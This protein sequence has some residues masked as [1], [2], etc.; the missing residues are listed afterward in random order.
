MGV[1]KKHFGSNMSQIE[2]LPNEVLLNIFKL[3][4][5]KDLYSCASVS[6][7]FRQIAYEEQLWS[8]LNLSDKT[9]PIAFVEQ[10][11]I[12]GTKYLSLAGTRLYGDKLDVSNSY[13]F[14]Y[15]LK[16]LDLTGCKIT[17]VSGLNVPNFEVLLDLTG[18][19]CNL[20]KLSLANLNLSNPR[21]TQNIIQN[22]HTLKVLDLGYCTGLK[23][24]SI[25]TIVDQCSELT[26]L[27]L[28]GSYLDQ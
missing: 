12:H 27:N 25:S 24:D 13:H 3:L 11:L 6:Q 8:T 9:I 17:K 21:W 4:N 26:E 2:K 16:Y 18:H 5:I 14:Q 23:F 7:R 19:C 10:I 20:E 15:N 28:D 22:C 1:R